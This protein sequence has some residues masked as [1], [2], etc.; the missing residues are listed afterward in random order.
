MINLHFKAHLAGIFGLECHSKTVGVSHTSS[1]HCLKRCSVKRQC[2]QSNVSL[3]KPHVARCRSSA[4]G[5]VLGLG[6]CQK[7]KE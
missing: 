2:L 6:I 3:I 5:G 4:S 7:S 1:S